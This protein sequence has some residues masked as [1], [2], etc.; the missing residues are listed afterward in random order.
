MDAATDRTGPTGHAHAFMGQPSHPA[1]SAGQ[2]WV[3]DQR[4]RSGQSSAPGRPWV[5]GYVPV[6]DGSTQPGEADELRLVWASLRNQ[7]IDR[8]HGMNWRHAAHAWQVRRDRPVAPWGVAFLYARPLPAEPG[9]PRY[10]AVA[11]ATRMVNEDRDIAEPAQLL[12]RLVGLA[13]H[14]YLAKTGV[15]DPTVMATFKDRISVPATYLGVGLSCLGDTMT[16]W[17]ELRRGDSDDIPG[18]CFGLLRDGTALYF[19]RAARR[20]LGKLRVHSTGDLSLQPGGGVFGACTYHDRY[21]SMPGPADVW[22][23][24]HALHTV[25]VSQPQL[26]V[27]NP[28]TASREPA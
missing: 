28:S 11:G 20:D 7:A 4:G 21:E 25:A 27:L 3:P 17:E 14:R 13:R 23:Q 16:A 1:W 26:P 22:E 15:F 6:W 12:F 10:C 19:H 18:E 2:T 8:L 5:N 24:L 9:W